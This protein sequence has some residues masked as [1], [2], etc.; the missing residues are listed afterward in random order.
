MTTTITMITAIMTKIPPP[1]AAPITTGSICS[2]IV[3]TEVGV[4][5]VG[6]EHP[7]AFSEF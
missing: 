7:K 3:P 1:A 4:V 6:L 2:A 5:P